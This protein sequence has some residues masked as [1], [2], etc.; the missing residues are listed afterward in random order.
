MTTMF[1]AAYYLRA[2]TAQLNGAGKTDDEGVA[3]TPESFLALLGRLDLTPEEHYERFGKF[4]G[5]NANAYFNE[6]EYLAAK[7]RQ[8]QSIGEKDANGAEYTVGSLSLLLASSGMSP[9]EHYSRFGAYETDAEGNFINPSNAFDVNAYL[10]AKLLHAHTTNSVVNDKTGAEISMDDLVAAMVESGLSPVEH[11][12]LYGAAEAVASNIPFVQTVPAE[13]RVAN[14]PARIVVDDVVPGNYNSATQAP[15]TV[16]GPTAPAKPA[17]VGGLFVSAESPE[18]AHPEW[19]LPVPGDSGYKAPPPGAVDSH[20]APLIPPSTRGAGAATDDWVAV[21]LSD[22]SGT[23]IKADGSLGG[24]LPPNSIGSDL[25]VPS[26]KPVPFAAVQAVGTETAE[27]FRFVHNQADSFA[28][29]FGVAGVHE[30]QSVD[31]ASVSLGVGQSIVIEQG[32]TAITITNNT[33]GALGGSNLA[34]FVAGSNFAP[35][36]W[37]ASSLGAFL[38]FTTTTGVDAPDLKVSYTTAVREV[39]S[40]DFAEVV[41]DVGE[42]LMI[43]DIVVC[44]NQTALPLSGEALALFVAAGRS[45]ADW[46]VSA[47]GTKAVFTFNKGGVVK[48]PLVAVY[49]AENTTLA[50]L[51]EA[52][53]EAGALVEL[54]VSEDVKGSPGTLSPSSFV[55][56]DEIIGFN[57]KQDRIKLPMP[58][59]TLIKGVADPAEI[60]AEALSAVAG[61]KAEQV[62]ALQAGLFA[63]DGQYYLFV[64]DADP[65]FSPTEDVVLKLTGLSESAAA[66]MTAEIFTAG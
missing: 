16:S 48:E 45:P 14:D 34:A 28:T 60:S 32:E 29:S 59:T 1:D 54:L 35:E 62:N 42:N 66:S 56:M 39:Q 64:N 57:P 26:I 50:I 8:L 52:K 2:K 19:S 7:V 61:E 20:A 63:F 41:L 31:L 44:A 40:I 5:L 33:G 46:A 25:V 15:E 37:T 21:S 10:S 18:V 65:T 47:S 43:G 58:V 23:V 49:G 13:Q 12:L 55:N 3:Y 36:G 11:Y 51:E 24:A 27:T 6:R 38:N 17:D 22:G 9:L 4:E 30:E 53:G